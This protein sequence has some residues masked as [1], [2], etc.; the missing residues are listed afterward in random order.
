MKHHSSKLMSA[1]FFI[2]ALG[3]NDAF[4]VEKP[5]ATTA[6]TDA[7]QEA[8]IWTTYVL[9]PYLSANHL[10]VSVKDGTAT[11][12]GKVEEDVN[13]ELAKEIALGVKGIKHVDNQIQ[14]ESDYV[15]AA[16]NGD[17]DY[18][19]VVNDATITA[20]VKSKIFWSKLSSSTST[21][22]ETN[23]GKVT[24]SGSVADQK[25]KKSLETLAYNT[26]GV[27]SVD[28]K[29]MVDNNMKDNNSNDQASADAK[30]GNVITDS[31]ITT[32][33]KSTYLY[34]S[35]VESSDISV[36]TEAGVV[37]LNGKVKSGAEQALAIEL[38]QNI[39]GVVS[40]ESKNLIF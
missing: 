38:A 11:L 39:R 22:V 17:R 28:N 19:D 7:R 14:V 16:R 31:W 30:S 37:T 34:S 36:T 2:L 26:K 24:L 20:A 33:V 27:L 4:A 25:T 23:N 21:E 6:V 9:S 40:V 8:Q 10:E 29:L 1:S 32:K 12:T 35:N 13:K 3:C 18:G 15:P 5:S